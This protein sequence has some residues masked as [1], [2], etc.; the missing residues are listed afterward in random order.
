MHLAPEDDPYKP[1]QAEFPV[2]RSDAAGHVLLVV[3]AVL[4]VIDLYLLLGVVPK[5]KVMFDALKGEL[6]SVTILVLFLSNFL[7]QWFLPLFVV[8]V[9]G[10]WIAYRKSVRIPLFVQIPVLVLL[11]LIMLS[12]PT[13][14]FYPILQLQA[15]VRGEQ[16][17]EQ[18][19]DKPVEPR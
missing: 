2:E 9:V 12:I 13:A 17:V 15:A 4:L 3:I 5:F 14:I 11:G 8:F 7:T 1:G 6:P 10:S 18:P 16:P 19:V